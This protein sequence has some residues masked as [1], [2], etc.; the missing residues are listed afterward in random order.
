MP[1]TLYDPS[2]HTLENLTQAIMVPNTG[3]S[4][5]PGTVTLKYGTSSEYDYWT[6]EYSDTTSVSFYDGSLPLNIG[7][8][9][10]LTSG[11][12]APPESNT[13]TSYGVSFSDG[14]ASGDEVDAQLQAVASAA[15]SGAGSIRDAS[16][17]TFQIQVSDPNVQSV[18]FN[19]VF[20]SD[21]YPEYAD[22][23]FV[24]IGAVLVN[25]VNYAL[26]NGESSQPLSVLQTNIDLDNFNDN[27]SGA[28][29]IEYD[30]VSKLLTVIAPVQQG[31]NTIK[32]GVADTGDQIY[33]S[34]L[35]IA[36]LEGVGYTGGGLSKVID[37]T[38]GSITTGLGN[39]V[40]QL[41]D[42]VS[43]TAFTFD[44]TNIGD[45][46][47]IGDQDDYIQAFFDFSVS[48]VL[49]YSY[50][51]FNELN[52]ANSLTLE[53]PYGTQSFVGADMMI[54]NDAAFALDTFKGGE[55]WQAF[56]LLKIAF[57]T[58]PTSDMLSQ[59]LKTAIDTDTL[60]DLAS[61]FLD[62][63]APASFAPENLVAYLY[64]VITG[65]AP[66]AGVA[67]SLTSFLAG[68]GYDTNAEILAFAAENYADTS[69]IEGYVL[70]VDPSYFI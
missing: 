51:P 69:A 23:T 61:A 44:T 59:W 55:T 48:E 33:D 58:D 42:D 32:I 13:S 4:L 39:L 50:S 43:K 11:D 54:F 47:I 40:Y 68:L 12:G 10:L 27:Q 26:F 1:Y 41:P 46:T 70:P 29:P 21:E 6:Y 15:F 19:V 49:G 7:S 60:T 45:K 18:R 52:Q 17:L 35:F 2:V 28:L 38:G 64:Q 20:G 25:D 24:D 5:A 57:G 66:A 37:V 65:T 34:G 22:S 30:G 36:N 9:L 8:G 62:A 31:L 53:T 14:Y 3:I 16:I 56:S 67:T 63:Y